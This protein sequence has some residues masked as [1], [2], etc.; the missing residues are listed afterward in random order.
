MQGE[1]LIQCKFIVCRVPRLYLNGN[2]QPCVLILPDRKSYTIMRECYAVRGV[3]L[4]INY[5][6]TAPATG[7]GVTHKQWTAVGLLS[8]VESCSVR[9]PPQVIRISLCASG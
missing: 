6:I 5:Q 3:V 9:L 8:L 7:P 4:T 1:R 2:P